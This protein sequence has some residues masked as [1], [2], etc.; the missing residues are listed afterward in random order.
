MDT[1]CSENKNSD[2]L[3]AV[4]VEAERDGLATTQAG[5]L[6]IFPHDQDSNGRSSREVTEVGKNVQKTEG[7]KD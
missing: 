3:I 2:D 5:S 4:F 6:P 1:P 7:W